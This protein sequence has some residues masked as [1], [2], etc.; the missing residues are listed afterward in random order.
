MGTRADARPGGPGYA[1]DLGPTEAWRLLEDD[2][3]ALLIDVRT[4]PEWSFVGV[5]DLAALG[6]ATVFVPWQGYPAMALNPSFADDLA[7]S[8]VAAGAPLVFIC[9]S[10]V[11]SAAAAALMTA[12]GFPRCYNLAGGFEGP[13]DAVGHRGGAGGWKAAGLPWKQS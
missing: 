6:K 7:A 11:R 12:R 9:R 1:G 8:G 3:S 10:G 5:P 4:P 13:L 2:P